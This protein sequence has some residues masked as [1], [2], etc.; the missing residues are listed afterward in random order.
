MSRI[1]TDLGVF[2]PAGDHLEAIKL[3][4]LANLA[5]IN[6]VTGVPVISAPRQPRRSS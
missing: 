2:R 4:P 5:Y 3:A 6:E 1:Y